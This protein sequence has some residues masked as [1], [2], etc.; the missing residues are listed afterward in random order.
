VLLDIPVLKVDSIELEV[1][2]L[3]AR[4]SLQAE[5]LNLLRLNVG[6]DAVLGQVRLD[7]RG[8]DAQALLKVRLDN[9]AEILDRVLSTIDAHPEIIEPLVRHAGVA[10]A[11]TG[12]GLGQFAQQSGAGAREAVQQVGAGVGDTAREAGRGVGQAAQQV[13]GG[14]GD[15][16]RQTAA[17]V[18]QAAQQ[19]GA[20]VGETAREAGDAAGQAAQRAG[21]E[22]TGAAT[23]RRTGKPVRKEWATD[24][25]DG[26][27]GRPSVEAGATVEA[28]GWKR[29]DAEGREGWEPGADVTGPTTGEGQPEGQRRHRG[30]PRRT[31][32][33]W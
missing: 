1:S 27:P 8:V 6:V 7:I 12:Q 30:L 32:R 25:G 5:V 15:T 24:S 17:G 18:G 22:A 23:A 3:R 33:R 28:A 4:V 19:A 14:V 26:G 10:L 29:T 9:V 20:G 31:R 21:G 2:D 11:Q 16:A 13:G